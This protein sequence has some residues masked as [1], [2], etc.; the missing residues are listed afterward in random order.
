[1][2]K[3]FTWKVIITLTCPNKGRVFVDGEKSFQQSTVAGK[4]LFTG[5]G[6]EVYLLPAMEKA[7]LVDVANGS[8]LRK[9]EADKCKKSIAFVR[10]PALLLSSQKR[11]NARKCELSL[12]QM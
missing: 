1:I 8:G 7:C 10:S 5:T 2:L 12:P 11:R 6:G 3:K 4:V 9:C